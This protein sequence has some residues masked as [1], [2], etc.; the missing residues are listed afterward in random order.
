[1]N[2]VVISIGYIGISILLILGIIS[3]FLKEKIR[4][5]NNLKKEKKLRKEMKINIKNENVSR[6]HLLFLN[7]QLSKT[8][9]LILFTKVLEECQ[10]K[11]K[12]LTEE[13]CQNISDIFEKL[14][15]EYRTKS[16]LEKAYFT[17]VLSKFPKLIQEDNKN[18]QYAMMH[19]VMD[20]SVYCRENAMLFFYHKGSLEGVINSLKKISS[21]KLYYSPKLLGDDLLKFTGDKQILLTRLLEEFDNFNPDFQLAI[22]NFCRFMNTDKKEEIYEKLISLKYDQE[23]NLSMIRYFGSIEYQPV[24]NYLLNILEDKKKY[25]FEYRLVASYAL[26]IYDNK[27]VRTALIENLKDKNWFVRKNTAISLSNM[28]LTKEEQKKIETLDDQYAK[29]MMRYVLEQKKQ[30][31]EENE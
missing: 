29:E 7:E 19:F 16:S 20:S 17:H 18:I 13:Y 1:M 9:N 28:N 10:K 25:S 8:Q 24:E 4:E 26:R 27:K 2:F 5:Q 23:V 11:N 6:S 31:E 14:V 22:M 12:S 30:K 21:R 15:K 3:F